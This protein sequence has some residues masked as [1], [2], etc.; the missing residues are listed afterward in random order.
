MKLTKAEGKMVDFGLERAFLEL[1]GIIR[2]PARLEEQCRNMI[3]DGKRKTYL[4]KVTA[5][6]RVTIPAPLRKE[7]GIKDDFVVIERLGDAVLIGRIK[8]LNDWYHAYFG[9]AAMKKGVTWEAAEKALG[10]AG[11]KIMRELYGDRQGGEEWP[12]GGRAPSKEMMRK[13]SIRC[14]CG[15]VTRPRMFRIKGFEVRGS[16]CPKCGEA[17]LNGADANR[18]LMFNKLRHW[19]LKRIDPD[20]GLTLSARTKR[21]LVRSRAQA[22]AGRIHT[23]EEVKKELRL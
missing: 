20:Y 23:L 8:T 12:D 6:G 11:P 2:D 1:R 14:P 21:E 18:H 22:K 4:V 13:E 7:L 9:K 5:G 17:F 16:E 10:K 15:G 3:K 19:V